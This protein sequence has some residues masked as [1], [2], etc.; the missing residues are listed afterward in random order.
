MTLTNTGGTRS[1]SR[2]HR[3]TGHRKTGGM[4]RS[5]SEHGTLRLPYD[6]DDCTGAIVAIQDGVSSSYRCHAV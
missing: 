3:K 2:G 1:G 6:D 4:P 5:S